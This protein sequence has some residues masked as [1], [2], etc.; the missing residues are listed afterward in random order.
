MTRSA[1]A[2]AV[3]LA[4]AFTIAAG[5]SGVWLWIARA[6]GFSAR[7]E[8]R[9]F[10]RMLARTARRWAVPANERDAVNPVA[11]SSEVWADS[12]AHFADHCASCHANDGSGRT[13]MGQNLYPRAPDMRLP[14]TQDLTDGELYWIIENGIRLTG[15][16]AWGSGRA[17]EADTWKLVHF[18]R[19][20]NDLSPAD[21]KIMKS[22]NPKT[23]AEL[24]EERDDERF[25]SGETPEASSPNSHHHLE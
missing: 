5:L 6:N 1:R 24:E 14:P 10:E 17:D 3:V 19:R 21:L 2:V 12:R 11:F 13:E 22:L 18:I 20:L 16:P 25:L 8:P 23:P 7:E 4:L 15:M 9:L